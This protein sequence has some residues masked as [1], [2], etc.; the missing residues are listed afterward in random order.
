MKN[1]PARRLAATLAALFLA[2]G[3]TACPNK[4]RPN[5]AA[6]PPPEPSMPADTTTPAS[7]VEQ[8][9]DVRPIGGESAS[10]SDIAAM[11]AA[12]AEAEGGPLADIH[13]DYDSAAL[14]DGARK[15]LEAHVV[16]LQSHR[17]AQLTVE[18]HCDE[19]GTVEYN[20][21]LG[22]Q[23]ARGARDYLVSLGVS[24]DRLRVVSFGKE[25]PLDQAATPEAYAKNRRAHFALVR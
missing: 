6:P 8:G 20:L 17:E 16:W 2:V 21:A 3:L 24:A 4:R 12:A 15:T 5:L 22:E 11:D 7:P 18:G 9:P 13:F 23:R 19:R 25:R 14:S 1:S 10:G